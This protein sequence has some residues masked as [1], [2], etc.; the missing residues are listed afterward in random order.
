MKSLSKLLKI[1]DKRVKIVYN[2]GNEI[3]N[4]VAFWQEKSRLYF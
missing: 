4:A 1:I 3:K 2:D